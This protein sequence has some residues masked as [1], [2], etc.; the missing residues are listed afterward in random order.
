MN[1]IDMVLLGLFSSF[2][3]PV[4]DTVMR[5]ISASGGGAAIWLLLGGLGLAN[6]AS[7]A[8]AWRALL[9]IGLTLLVTDAVLKPLIARPRPVP[10]ESALARGLPSAPSNYS[11]PSGHA[12]SGVGAAIALSRMWPQAKVILWIGAALISY[13]RIYLGHHYPSDVLAGALLGTVLAI[14][15]LGGRHRATY[16]NTLPH[17]L[18][19]GVVVRP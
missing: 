16:A 3:T 13:A 10:P 5:L 18:P 2:H 9:T 15:V 4:L 17:P 1:S 6:P 14:W 8:A 19:D 12:A 7:R 11:M